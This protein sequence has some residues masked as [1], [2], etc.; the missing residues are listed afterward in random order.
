MIDYTIKRSECM[1]NIR[2]LEEKDYHLY[3]RLIDQ[4]MDSIEEIINPAIITSNGEDKLI[5]ELDGFYS[6]A[7]LNNNVLIR[8]EKSGISN[9]IDDQ[10]HYQM[11]LDADIPIVSKVNLKTKDMEQLFLS[12]P[13]EDDL[14]PFIHYYQG[15]RNGE[16][17]ELELDY[18]ITNYINRLDQFFNYINNRHPDIA[19]LVLLKKYLLF[20]YRSHESY[21]LSE[22][23]RQL[24][25][26]LDTKYGFIRL[27][28]FGKKYSY[29][30]FEEYVK[31]FGFNFHINHE[32]SEIFM[33]NNQRINNYSLVLKQYDDYMNRR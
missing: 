19:L 25:R 23:E 12:K 3:Q 2:K 4:T 32:L 14:H 1:D 27:F 7:S 8:K 9:V 6:I 28:G 30:D 11:Y 10:Y 17:G 31:Q 29:E 15:K 13:N 16:E 18:D 5:C 21:A 24:V 26:C 22:E 20:K 33:K